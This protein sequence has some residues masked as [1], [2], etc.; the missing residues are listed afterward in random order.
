MLTNNIADIIGNLS[1]F[2]ENHSSLHNLSDMGVQKSVSND[3]LSSLLLTPSIGQNRHSNLFDT[4]PHMG[5]INIR[6]RFRHPG[7]GK[8]KQQTQIKSK[9]CRVFFEE[10]FNGSKNK[11]KLLYLYFESRKMENIPFFVLFSL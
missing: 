2:S 4:S 7:L 6:Q 9:Q 3:N 5:R 11:G 8:R 10:Y 1:R